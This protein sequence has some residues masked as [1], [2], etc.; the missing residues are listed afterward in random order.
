MAE[1][2]SGGPRAWPLADHPRPGASRTGTAVGALAAY[3]AVIA[4]VMAGRDVTA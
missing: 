4:A 1:A 2:R 3:A